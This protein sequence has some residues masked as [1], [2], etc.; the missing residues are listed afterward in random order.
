MDPRLAAIIALAE[1][2]CPQ[3]NGAVQTVPGRLLLADGDGLCYYCAG[4]EDT[5]PG[6][7]R[8]NLIDKLRAAKAACG[9]EAVKILVT[10]RGSH[11]GYRYAV[12]RVKPYQAQ[13]TGGNRPKNW[14]YLRSLLEE[15]GALADDIEVEF[16]SIAEADDLF[17][18]Y[19]LNHPDCVIYTQDKDMRMV[20]GWHLDWLTHILFRVDGTFGMTHN[21]KVWGRRFFWQQVLHGDTADNIPGLPWYTD[22]S[23]LKS[24]PEKGQLKQTKC[25]EKAVPVLALNSINDDMSALLHVQPLYQSCYGDRWV[26]ELLEQGILLWMRT[27]MQS[28]PFNVVAPGNPLAAL[29]T[30][31]LYPAARAEMMQRIAEAVVYETGENSGTEGA[32]E[33]GASALEDEPCRGVVGV[34]TSVSSGEEETGHRPV[35]AGKQQS[36]GQEVRVSSHHYPGGL[37]AARAVSAARNK[38]GGR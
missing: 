20:T 32:T 18:R 10:A 1:T 13:R 34:P 14:E 19:A 26:V 7:A 12:A 23:V 9:A 35:H 16:T 37:L 36:A 8:Q 28:S 22:G 2:Q 11:K 21:E 6:R 5:E 15:G 17:S 24:G 25:G 33:A 4:N 3:S 31:A 38:A 27:D 29:T 30:H